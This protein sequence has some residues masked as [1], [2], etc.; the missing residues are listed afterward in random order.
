M[1]RIRFKRVKEALTYLKNAKDKSVLILTPVADEK[2]IQKALKRAGLAMSAH[3]IALEEIDEG[4]IIPFDGDEATHILNQYKAAVDKAL[5]VSKTDKNG[6]ITYANDHFARCSG[7]S[8]EELVGRPHNI[9]RH[10]D[11]PAKTFKKMWKTILA[12]KPWQGIIKNLNKQGKSYYVDATIYPILDSNGEIL[13]FIALRKDVTRQME[14]KEKLKAKERELQTIL[15][16]LDAVTLYVSKKKGVL[17]VNRRFFDYFDFK[18]IKEF[19]KKHACI[20]D[21]FLEEEGYIYP[22]AREDWLDFVSNNPDRRHKVKMRDKE[23]KTRTFLLKVTPLGKKRFVLTLNDI[24]PMEEAL[25]RA[26]LNEHAKS[27]FVANMS[28]EIRTPLNGI[29]GFTELLLKKE[30]D[31]ETARYL[32]IIHQSGQTLLGIVNDILDLSKIESDAMRL[33]PEPADLVQ[34]LEG[35]ATVFAAKAKEKHIDYAVFIDPSI[36]PVVCDVLRIKQV[37]GNLINNA[38]KFTPEYGEIRLNVELKEQTAEH[39]TVKFCVQDT[40]IGIT[41]QQQARIFTPFSQADETIHKKFGGTGLGLPISARFVEMMGSRIQLKSQKGEG[42]TFFFTLTFPLAKTALLVPRTPKLFDQTVHLFVPKEHHSALFETVCHYLKVWHITYRE[43][44]TPQ[45]LPHDALLVILSAD[46]LPK[47]PLQKWRHERPRLHFAC[48]TNGDL[49]PPEEAYNLHPL[50][51]PVIGST[52][53]DLLTSVFGP[54]TAAPAQTAKPR[55]TPRFRGKVLVAEDNPVNR[56]LIT[57]LL[58]ERGLEIVTAQNGTEAIERYRAEGPFGLILMDINM[59]ETDG[60]ASA[61][62]L[63]KEG[64]Q[65]PI[66]ALTAN[67]MHDEKARYLKLGFADH[68]AKPIDSAALDNV[69]RAYLS[70]KKEETEQP[71]FD[72]VSF[73]PLKRYLGLK[74]EKVLST[75]LE[76]FANSVPAQIEEIE[77]AVIHNDADALAQTLHKIK[78]AVGN[79]RF[80]HAYH[81]T[82]QLEKALKSTKPARLKE[83]LS[84]LSARLWDLKEKI[85]RFLANNNVDT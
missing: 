47:L 28:H 75:L 69:L 44:P 22:K 66:V 40:G 5:L 72:T 52:L 49:T 17:R 16:N 11:M 57:E 79:M 34:E 9:V 20:C 76:R 26:R 37:L 74:N 29:L 84:L 51:I 83:E 38:V 58:K 10:P 65:T 56:L 39:A 27:Q 59:P 54:S 8:P 62:T 73:A 1:K 53:F 32:Q 77:K 24:T 4:A 23:G 14:D 42:A 3:V 36:P 82:L 15:N 25:M 43:H 35:I 85:A 78:G 48:L 2:K 33:H 81:Q 71:R 45:T 18:N 60:V 7:Y 70:E 13:E 31:A 68:L 50:Q 30:L 61:L 80:E 46:D 6:I 21:L 64:C 12:K 67:A 41:P 55:Q 19:K 63:L